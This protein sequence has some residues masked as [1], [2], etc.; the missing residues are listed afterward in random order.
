MGARLH[1]RRPRVPCKGCNVLPGDGGPGRGH[2]DEEKSEYGTLRGVCMKE[3]VLFVVVLECH[4][5]STTVQ[6]KPTV[7]TLTLPV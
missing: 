1:P 7:C 6:S 5:S 3:E 4:C 2:V